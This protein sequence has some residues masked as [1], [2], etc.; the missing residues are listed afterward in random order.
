MN[1]PLPPS[2]GK[3][4]PEGGESVDLASL[5][6]AAKLGKQKGKL[7]WRGDEPGPARTHRRD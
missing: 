1:I 3:A 6:F 2:K 5:A 7:L 4:E